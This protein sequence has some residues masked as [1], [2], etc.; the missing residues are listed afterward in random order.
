MKTSTLRDL[1][2]PLKTQIGGPPRDTPS[3]GHRV[4]GTPTPRD[5]PSAGHPLLAGGAGR[6]G[7]V[8]RRAEKMFFHAKSRNR[9]E[10][11]CLVHS[12]P[13]WKNHPKTLSSRNT[14]VQNRH[15]KQRENNFIHNFIQKRF[16]PVTLSS[17]TVSSEFPSPTEPRT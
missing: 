1:N 9:E 12:H 10:M 11:K 13:N 3:A 2:K 17:K 7:G 5:T 6:G 14:S 4:R 8:P 15:P 16:H